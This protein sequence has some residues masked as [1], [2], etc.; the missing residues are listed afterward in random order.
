MKV[1]ESLN[2]EK[3]AQFEESALNDMK[4]FVGGLKAVATYATSGA[5]C[6]PSGT[7]S[8]SHNPATDTS[9]SVDWTNVSC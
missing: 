1:L 9:T 2:D 8:D 7:A 3:F 4:Q 6:I 5:G